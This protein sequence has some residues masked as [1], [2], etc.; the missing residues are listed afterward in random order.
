MDKWIEGRM[1]E[2]GGW[3]DGL[4]DGQLLFI[5]ILGLLRFKERPS[6]IQNGQNRFRALTGARK[7]KKKQREKQKKNS[8]FAF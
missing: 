1:Y 4:M 6:G 3:M 2:N 8:N 7:K 5:L